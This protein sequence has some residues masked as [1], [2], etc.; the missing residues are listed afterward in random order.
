[1]DLTWLVRSIE[2]W[3][4]KFVRVLAGG[5]M[6]QGE[7]GAETW[8]KA[9]LLMRLIVEEACHRWLLKFRGDTKVSEAICS[10]VI[11]LKNLETMRKS[12][13][14]EMHSLFWRLNKQRVLSMYE[15]VS[16]GTS[17]FEQ[18]PSYPETKVEGFGPMRG[19][20]MSLTNYTE[21]ER[22]SAQQMSLSEA[23]RLTVANGG[24]PERAHDES[25]GWRRSK[26]PFALEG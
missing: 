2:D 13:E 14:D 16:L 1:M 15:Q 3:A 5:Y 22:K 24:V 20:I 25:K 4:S 10:L 6:S 7:P 23:N 18:M 21:H 26:S 11:T 9:W 12:G 17:S 8:R 19:E